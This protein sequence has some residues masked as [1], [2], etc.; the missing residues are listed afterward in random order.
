MANQIVYGIGE[1][2]CYFDGNRGIYIG[3]HV[4]SMAYNNGWRPKRDMVPHDDE[5]YH[6]AIDE[7]ED[8]LNDL[9][10]VLD[11]LA[12]G[13]TDSGDWGLWPIDC[14][15]CVGLGTVPVNTL[16]GK[17]KDDCP[18]CDGTGNVVKFKP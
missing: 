8:F 11:G 2:G 5:F 15:K 17:F 4:Q 6:E 3:E 13:S 7:A 14:E 18:D 9:P 12:F 10:G 16:A 1:I